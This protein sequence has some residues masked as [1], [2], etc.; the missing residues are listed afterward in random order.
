MTTGFVVSAH[1]GV[2]RLN[3]EEVRVYRDNVGAQKVASSGCGHVR[4]VRTH[5]PI[6]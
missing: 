2:G 1:D 3:S 5:W 6:A 4:L